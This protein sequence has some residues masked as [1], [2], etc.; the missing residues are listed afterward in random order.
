MNGQRLKLQGKSIRQIVTFPF[1]E[2]LNFRSELKE[3]VILYICTYKQECI[4]N[5]VMYSA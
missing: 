5:T 2:D 3:A 4:R 1:K